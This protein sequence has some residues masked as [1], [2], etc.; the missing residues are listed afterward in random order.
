MVVPV[1][2]VVITNIGDHNSQDEATDAGKKYIEMFAAESKNLPGV[3]RS[4][5]GQ[6]YKYP[7]TVMHFIGKCHRPTL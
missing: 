5:W 4:C 2:E 1:I 3:V 6:S 7:D